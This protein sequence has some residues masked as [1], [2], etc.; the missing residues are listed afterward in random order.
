MVATNR[1]RMKIHTEQNKPHR[2]HTSMSQD[3]RVSF[4]IIISGITIVYIGNN[5]NAWGMNSNFPSRYD[6]S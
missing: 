1:W 2:N 6:C 4:T 3:F 5:S